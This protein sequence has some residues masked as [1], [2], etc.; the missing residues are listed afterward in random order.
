MKIG[1]CSMQTQDR[2]MSGFGTGIYIC[3]LGIDDNGYTGDMR[4]RQQSYQKATLSS[5][6][7]WSTTF[8]RLI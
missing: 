6:I 8:P 7:L 5:I 4:G 3:C 2:I 1:A